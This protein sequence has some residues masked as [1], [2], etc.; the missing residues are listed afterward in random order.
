MSLCVV[1]LECVG[2]DLVTLE[3]TANGGMSATAEMAP[4]DIP[5]ETQDESGEALFTALAAKIRAA[6]SRMPEPPDCLMVALPGA[7]ADGKVI[8]AGRLGIRRPIDGAQLLSEHLDVEVRLA[9]DME[10]LW[11]A[12]PGRSAD[13]TVSYVYLDEGIGG[14]T[15]VDGKPLLGRGHAGILGRL[16]M[17]PMGPFSPGLMARGVLEVYASRPAI[18][19]HM[20]S[21]YRQQFLKPQAKSPGEETPLRRALATLAEA[22][23]DPTSLDYSLMAGG[24]QDDDPIAETVLEMA[25]QHLGLALSTLLTIVNPH[26][27]VLAGGLVQGL[28]SVVDRTLHYVEQYTASKPLAGTEI[29]RW[30]TGRRHLVEGAAALYGAAGG[31]SWPDDLR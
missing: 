10:C 4:L 14:F 25:A 15:V 7:L 13:E 29:E 17:N 9:H 27:L 1:C 23:H 2:A 16:V 5:M 24:L 11:R 18:S 31:V 3:E 30:E 26:R 21:Q 6:W 19:D 8:S 20:V 22:G 28:P 12:D